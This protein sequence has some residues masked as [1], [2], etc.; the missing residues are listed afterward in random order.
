MRLPGSCNLKHFK[1][2][3][4]QKAYATAYHLP[5]PKGNSNRDSEE[6]SPS[7]TQAFLQKEVHLGTQLLN[8][9]H[10]A[11]SII[12]HICPPWVVRV[13]D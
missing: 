4:V 1:E 13:A 3:S 2:D 11:G 7:M 9:L 12:D 6:F 8:L 5:T 10:H